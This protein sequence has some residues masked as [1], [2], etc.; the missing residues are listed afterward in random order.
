M[1]APF[2]AGLKIL[3]FTALLPGPFA[4][5][6][7]ADLGADVIKVEPPTGDFT[8]RMSESMFKT[9][10]RNKRSI[11]IDLKNPASA[12]IV[13]R[14]AAW[15]DVAIEGFRPGVADRLKIGAAQ[16]RTIKPSL[17]YCSI[18][19]YGQS[20]PWRDWPGHDG[21]YLAASGAL[22]FVGHW[23]DKEPR[24]SGIPVADLAGAS[25]A[26]ISI[27]A[28]VFRA[29]STGEGA[30]IDLSLTDAAM[31]FMSV[32]A[33]LDCAKPDR[34]HLWPT[35]DVFETSDGQRFAFGIVEEHFWQGFVEAA[36]DVTPELRDP[37]FGDEPARRKHG[38]ELSK[39]LAATIKKLA[40]ADW[41][42]RFAKND[43]PAQRVLTPDEAT[44]SDYT[45]ARGLVTGKSGQ[46]HLPFPALVDGQPAGTVKHVA[47]ALGADSRTVLEALGFDAKDAD[48]L[49]KSGAVAAK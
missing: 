36:G 24:R 42:A 11:A 19:G 13:E 28:A 29:R 45:K 49:I 41:L 18:S 43:V 22:S 10:N 4:T 35:N 8:R 1:T 44:T 14:L 39:I 9:A 38:D 40:A 23:N 48:D 34:A 5:V 47:P 7:L 6:M 12:K 33:G 17:V 25:Y 3:D 27:L 32:R 2:L 15:A 16:L 21:N 26:A 37:R 31:S 30:T 46:R 20:G